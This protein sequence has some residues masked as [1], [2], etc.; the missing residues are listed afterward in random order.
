LRHLGVLDRHHAVEAAR[1]GQVVEHPLSGQC[2]SLL[3]EEGGGG[4]R[5]AA[6]DGGRQ[7]GSGARRGGTIKIV[8]IVN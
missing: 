7:C 4:G 1:L 3:V 2:S 6:E 8:N 5:A